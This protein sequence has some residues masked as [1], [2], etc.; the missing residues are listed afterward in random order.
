[1][2]ASKAAAQAAGEA[3]AGTAALS[4]SNP[5]RLLVSACNQQS[6]I[7]LSGLAILLHL[8]SGGSLSSASS[9]QCL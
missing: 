3:S 1:M 9:D 4:C 2:L 5:C 6:G 7:L 8:Q